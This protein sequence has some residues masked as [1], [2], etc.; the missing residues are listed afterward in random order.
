MQCSSSQGTWKLSA[1]K[2]NVSDFQ[3]KTF[4]HVVDDEIDAAAIGQITELD[5]GKLCV[6]IQGKQ[7]ILGHTSQYLLIF[8]HT[9]SAAIYCETWNLV[10]FVCF[11]AQSAEV[12]PYKQVDA[13]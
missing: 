6:M 4:V 5:N 12:F 10:C 9:I 1:V 3:K 13:M 7:K 11:Q 8:K 2:V